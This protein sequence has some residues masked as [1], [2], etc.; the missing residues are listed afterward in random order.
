MADSRFE[1]SLHSPNRRLEIRQSKYRYGSMYDF[2][3]RMGMIFIDEQYITIISIKSDRCIWSKD[4]RYVGIM[5]PC[6]WRFRY[7]K[8]TERQWQVA[9]YDFCTRRLR[10]FGRSLCDA[11]FECFE[12]GVISSEIVVATG[13]PWIRRSWPLAHIGW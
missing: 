9:V 11:R 5:V 2:D 10:G 3:A 13:N 7:G 6:H 1:S 8:Q 12:H 4:L